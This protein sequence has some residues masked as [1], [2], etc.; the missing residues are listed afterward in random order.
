MSQH[1]SWKA[2]LAAAVVLGIV[3]GQTCAAQTCP[4]S[5]V[6]LG[7]IWMYGTFSTNFSMTVV[8]LT[9]YQLTSTPRASVPIPV[10]ASEDYPYPFQNLMEPISVAP[11]RS[12]LWKSGYSGSLLDPQRYAGRIRFQLST[13]VGTRSFEVNFA[14]QAARGAVPGRGTWIALSQ[15]KFAPVTDEPWCRNSFCGGVWSTP[16]MDPIGVDLGWDYNMH[17]VM[18]LTTHDLVVALYSPDNLS[19]VL[20]V[21]QTHGDNDYAPLLDFVDNDGRSVPGDCNN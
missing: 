16:W 8:N 17:N 21:R 19:I 18:T 3:G 7:G 1:A 12:V 6:P 20:V 15:V 13:A 10:Y 4:S 9:D 5:N 14:T 2:A 11:Y